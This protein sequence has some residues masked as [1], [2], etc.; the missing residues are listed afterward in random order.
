MAAALSPLLRAGAFS[1]KEKQD[2]FQLSNSGIRMSK[3][4]TYPTMAFQ[5]LQQKTCLKFVKLSQFWI[6]FCIYHC[7]FLICFISDGQLSQNIYSFFAQ[8]PGTASFSQKAEKSRP[9]LPHGQRFLFLKTSL[10]KVYISLIFGGL[11]R[12]GETSPAPLSASEKI[13]PF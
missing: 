8:F 5:F 9:F 7:I 6:Y 4:M 2:A 3:S 13:C 10:L 11:D 1:G 12:P